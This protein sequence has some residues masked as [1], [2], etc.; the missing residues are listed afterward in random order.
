MKNKHI[1]LS[2]IWAALFLLVVFLSFGS[3]RFRLKVL[4]TESF[5]NYITKLKYGTGKERLQDESRKKFGP[6]ADY[7]FR[8]NEDDTLVVYKLNNKYGFINVVTKQIEIDSKKHDFDYAWSFDHQSGLAAVIS[9]SKIGFINKNG[10]FKIDPIYPYRKKIND[11]FNCVFKDG[12]CII[13]S[14]NGKKYG[15]INES[16]VL[17]VP[18]IYEFI[19]DLNYGY[20][21]VIKDEK[22]GLLDSTFSI[23]MNTIYDEISINK[24]GIVILNAAN[25][26]QQLLGFDLKTII[27]KYVFDNISFISEEDL[28]LD[29]ETDNEWNQT[30]YLGF[31]TFT[32]N[33]NVGLLRNLDGKILI[34]ANCWDN[35]EYFGGDDIFKAQLD[36]QY[37]L[38]NSKGQFI[39]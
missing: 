5:N 12:F 34:E 4:F 21:I 19:G 28:S 36:E 35:I 26:S 23:A 33:G 15:L 39:H 29:E 27:T 20:R 25:N 3:A 11:D 6:K 37:F 9:D 17:L 13:P 18:I 31:S 32:I 7:F 30:H 1:F 22:Y 16:N 24:L 8:A 14:E 10:S 38:I 2:A